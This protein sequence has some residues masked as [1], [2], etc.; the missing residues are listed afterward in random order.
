MFM[1]EINGKK[2][3]GTKAAEKIGGQCLHC[4][5]VTDV[6]LCFESY[7]MI[8]WWIY[9]I[10]S[11]DQTVDIICDFLALNRMPSVH[12]VAYNCSS[13]AAIVRIDC[14]L[15][16]MQRDIF[17][18][19]HWLMCP[20]IGDCEAN[21]GSFWGEISLVFC[22]TGNLQNEHKNIN[23][24]LNWNETEITYSGAKKYLGSLYKLYRN[25]CLCLSTRVW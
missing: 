9:F 16:N 3:F 10:F 13:P 1:E 5:W 23:Y 8:I 21:G 6:K 4:V 7:I 25:I 17:H 19:C 11:P 20:V 14:S 24:L 12:A 15:F 18:L 2:C 22:C